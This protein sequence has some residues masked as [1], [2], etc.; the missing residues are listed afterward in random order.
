MKKITSLKQQLLSAKSDKSEMIRI[1]GEIKNMEN[2]IN[3]SDDIIRR[4]FDDQDIIMQG[5]AKYDEKIKTRADELEMLKLE[6]KAME[7]IDE[8]DEPV[9]VVRVKRKI[10]A[11]TKIMGPKSFMVVK[12]NLGACKIMEI[13][14]SDPDD[15]DGRQMVIQ[16]L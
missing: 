6:K 4:I 14:S 12:H 11:G 3:E 5:I 1:A 10:L 9:P 16:N 8:F 13:D 7:E 2:T 15:R